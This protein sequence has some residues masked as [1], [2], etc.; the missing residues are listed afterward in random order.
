MRYLGIDYGE[1][2]IGLAVSDPD[3]KIAFPKKIIFNHGRRKVLKE[4]NLLLHE[5]KISK[6]I[7]GLPLYLDGSE[8]GESRQVRAF[9]EELKKEVHLPVEFENEMLTTHIVE[10]AGVPREHTDQAAAALIL[11][12]YLDKHQS[13]P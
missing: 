10:M 11:Q 2:R 12:S 1:K 9:A 13:E 6:I 8:S 5:E 4:L 3:G 7:V